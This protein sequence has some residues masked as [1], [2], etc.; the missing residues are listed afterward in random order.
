MNVGGVREGIFGNFL[1]PILSWVEFLSSAAGGGGSDLVEKAAVNT[2][3]AFFV[4]APAAN[5]PPAAAPF[6]SE[7]SILLPVLFFGLKFTEK[8]F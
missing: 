1:S 8:Q 2:G 6:T 4:I 3:V 7:G 5:L